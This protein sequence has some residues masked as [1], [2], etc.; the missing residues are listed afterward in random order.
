MLRVNAAFSKGNLTVAASN[1]FGTYAGIFS[2]YANAVPFY[3]QSGMIVPNVARPLTPRTYTV[4]YTLRYGPGALGSTHVAQTLPAPGGGRG[5]RGEGGPGGGGF[6]P[7]PL[8]SSAPANPLDVSSDDTALPGRRTRNRA[9]TF[10]R[11]EGLRCADRGG[12]DVRGISRNDAAAADHR[13]D[14]HLSWDGQHLRPL[15]SATLPGPNGTRCVSPRKCSPLRARAR[16]QD[17]VR[18][19][20]G[21]VAAIASAAAVVSSASS[22]D[23]S[24]CTLHS[25]T[26]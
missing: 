22:S 5:G 13:R 25:P 12:E 18:K 21:V 2:S 4:T 14:R 15:D 6:R 16:L 23:A 11:T 1:I 10:E 20:E 8:P 7:Q 9:A 26:K 24:R 17:K 3:T 19:A